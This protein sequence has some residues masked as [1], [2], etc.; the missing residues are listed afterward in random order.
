MA[1]ADHPEWLLP[2]CQLQQGGAGS[3][4]RSGS[5]SGG[6]RTLVPRVPRQTI[7]SHP[8][9]HRQAGSAPRPGATAIA[10]ISLPAAFWEPGSSWPKAQPRLKGPAPRVSGS[11]VRG[12]QGPCHLQ[13]K[14]YSRQTVPRPAP[15]SH[16]DGARL[17]RPPA[18]EQHSQAR[19]G[20]LR[21]TK[22]RTWAWDGARLHRAG[23]S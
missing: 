14:T 13:G 18:A 21:G 15:G 1:A 12:W 8:R 20:R 5:S 4:S 17:S 9:S 3:G 2:S 16:S 7:V 19:K 10:S 11:F 6:L 23:G 22:R